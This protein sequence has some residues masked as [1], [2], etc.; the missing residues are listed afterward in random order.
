MRRM[1]ISIFASQAI[2]KLNLTIMER[3]LI[4]VGKTMSKKIKGIN[5]IS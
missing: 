5:G 1:K 2:D 4:Y 3:W